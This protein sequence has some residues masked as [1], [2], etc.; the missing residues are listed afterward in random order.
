MFFL[1]VISIYYAVDFFRLNT[2]FKVHEN[3]LRKVKQDDVTT[4]HQS[5]MLIDMS[6]L[7]GVIDKLQ[8]NI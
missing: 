1:M 6:T 4:P 7:K 8:F 5:W 2:Q 3:M